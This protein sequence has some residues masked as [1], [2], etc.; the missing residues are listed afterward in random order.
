MKRKIFTLSV[1]I[2]C[3]FLIN[4]FVS[5]SDV[6]YIYKSKVDNN[7]IGLFSSL[8]L[9]TDLIKETALI[10]EGLPKYKFIF[11]GDENFIKEIPII[12]YPSVISNYHLGKKIG[13]TD[14][15]GVSKLVSTKP[16]SVNFKNKIIQVYKSAADSK[17]FS[18]PY[19]FLDNENKAPALKMIAGTYS[20]SSGKDFGDVVAF[21]YKGDALLNNNV[22]EENI[23]F[24][25]IIKSDYWTDEAKNLFKK[26]IKHVYNFDAACHADSDCGSD[27]ST[28]DSFCSNN[29]VFQNYTS[30]KCNNPGAD[31]SY[32]SSQTI[33]KLEATC[34]RF[35]IKGLCEDNLRCIKNKDCDDNNTNTEDICL[36]PGLKNSSC[37]YRN[38]F[39]NIITDV[40]LLLLTASST[41]TTVTLTF[42]AAPE[43]NSLVKG[44]LLKKDIDNWISVS[45][46][47]SSYIFTN[48]ISST[49]YVFYAKAVDNLNR[50]SEELNISIRTADLPPVIPPAPSGGGGGGGNTIIRG[51]MCITEWKC[52]EWGKCKNGMQTRSCSYPPNFCRP[53]EDKPNE[54]QSCIEEKSENEAFISPTMEKNEIPPAEI[55]TAK[56]PFP[57][58]GAAIAAAIGKYSWLG[59]IVFLI[60]VSSVYFYLKMRP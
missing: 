40:K 30:F 33:T 28:G 11:V 32:C 44:Y 54:S 36:N 19:Y 21:G 52:T 53:D 24:F 17:G 13:L 8:N 1:F 29:S 35:C 16:L 34:F 49:N 14:N 47:E 59:L 6:A 43:N 9:K 23:C 55:E 15:E 48:L 46:N 57:I 4:S 2:A 26:C 45:N 22:L 10:Q 60:G 18:I 12:K 25:G 37:L 38:N 51:S 58:T 5:A 20:T 39:T 42:A 3:V 50:T 41:T 31:S 7:I 27:S 56:K